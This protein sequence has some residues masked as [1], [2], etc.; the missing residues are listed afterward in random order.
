MKNS[1]SEE[2]RFWSKV[3]KT[4]QC[5][6]WIAS[7]LPKGYGVFGTVKEKRKHILAHRYSYKYH[8]GD[9]DKKMFV[10]HKCDNPSCVNPEHLFLGNNKLNMEDAN[11]KGRM[12]YVNKHN[13]H[14][15]KTHCKHGHEYNKVNTF[16]KITKQGYKQ[17][18]CKICRRL[19]QNILYN[20]K[21]LLKS[22]I[23]S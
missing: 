9:F 6:I 15:N 2:Q 23:T 7:K 21:K 8:F 5:W 14:K 17:R 20:K 19:Q 4:D 16:I 18:N 10:C 22:S 11:K 13:I 3:N 12:Y 1:L